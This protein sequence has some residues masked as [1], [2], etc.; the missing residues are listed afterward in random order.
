MARMISYAQNGEDVL[1]NRLF[2]TGHRGFYIDVGACHPTLH[3]VTRHFYDQGWSGVNIEPVAHVYEMLAQERQ[4]DVNLNVG[5]SNHEG[6]LEFHVSRDSLGMSTFSREFARSL[7]RDGFV[8][9][10]RTVAV[11]TLAR[12]CEAYASDRTIDFLKVDVE[13][14]ELEVISGGDWRRWRPRVVLVEA[15]DA[16]AGSWESLLRDADYQFAA[17][18]GLNRYYVRVEDRDLLPRFTKPVNVLDDYISHEH[19]WAISEQ[20]RQADQLRD[21]LHE[22]RARWAIAEPSLSQSSI[23]R[24]ERDEARGR[25]SEVAKLRAERDRALAV[26]AAAET[27]LEKFRDLGPTSIALARRFRRV[28]RQ[29]P[30][31]AR[32]VKRVLRPTG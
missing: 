5:V 19:L 1:L 6:L 16:E 22:A 12:L 7:E 24:D 13:S 10:P 15:P 2:P 18:D 23:L 28:G 14:H 29:F 20:K 31:A 3:S 17:F 11:T 21:E 8:C 27:E 9:E 30:A 4:R 26:L 32:L 25:L